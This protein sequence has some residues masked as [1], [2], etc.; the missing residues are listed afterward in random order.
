MGVDG[1]TLYEYLH[2]RRANGSTEAADAPRPEVQRIA[3]ETAEGFTYLHY[4]SIVHRDIKSQNVLLTSF[5]RGVKICDF[6]LARR[7]S[8]LCTGRM[9]WA[10]TPSY[11]APELFRKQTYTEKV[12]V[13]AFGALLYELFLREVPFDGLDGAD[14]SEKWESGYVPRLS[15]ALPRELRTLILSCYDGV[16]ANRPAMVEVVPSLAVVPVD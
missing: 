3:L 10:G 8:D 13:F 14:I 7:K 12:D 11:M 1:G 9:Q 5:T 2:K 4:M 6:G 16:A 15:S